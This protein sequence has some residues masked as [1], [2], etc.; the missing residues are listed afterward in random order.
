MGKFVDKTMFHSAPEGTMS[1]K[2]GG[3]D[4]Y[5]RIPYPIHEAITY[6]PNVEPTN[7]PHNL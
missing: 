1:K 5:G 3:V 4:G 6:V 7:H 2:D